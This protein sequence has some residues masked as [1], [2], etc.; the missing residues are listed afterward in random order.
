VSQ[1]ITEFYAWNLTEYPQKTLKTLNAGLK[2]IERIAIFRIRVVGACL[3]AIELNP[4]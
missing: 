2:A 1:K 4:A 3:R